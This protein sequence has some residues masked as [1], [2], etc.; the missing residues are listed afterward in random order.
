[1]EAVEVGVWEKETPRKVS[2]E[3]IAEI[4][5]ERFFSTRATK[6]DREQAWIRKPMH[7]LPINS[8]TIDPWSSTYDIED[9]PCIKG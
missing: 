1:M 7:G 9:H 8:G 6:Q 4:H 3:N 2:E 5:V